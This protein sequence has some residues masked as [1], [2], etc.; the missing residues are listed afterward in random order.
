MEFITMS[1]INNIK[2]GHRGGL[3]PTPGDIT[4][5]EPGRLVVAL[6]TVGPD[7]GAEARLLITASFFRIDPSRARMLA[8]T[9]Q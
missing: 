5:G 1:R 9:E 7:G 8:T 4:A 2:D 3:T 6:A